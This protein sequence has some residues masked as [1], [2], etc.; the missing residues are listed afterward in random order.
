MPEFDRLMRQSARLNH[1]KSRL[2]A[3]LRPLIDWI[4]HR[5]VQRYYQRHGADK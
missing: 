4:W 1:I 3:P 5:E 2:P